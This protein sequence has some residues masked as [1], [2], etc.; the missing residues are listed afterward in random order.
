MVILMN[1]ICFSIV[2]KGVTDAPSVRFALS[3]YLSNERK[4]FLEKHLLVAIPL[5]Q[6]G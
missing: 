2:G 4:L 5:V 6:T 3:G 1:I